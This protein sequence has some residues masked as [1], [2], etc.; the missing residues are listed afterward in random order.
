MADLI[1]KVPE[2]NQSSFIGG[3]NLLGDDSRLQPTQYRAG[4]DLTN[5]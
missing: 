2:Y 4:F 1:S 5:R 3:M